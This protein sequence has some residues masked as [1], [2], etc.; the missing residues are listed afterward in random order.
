MLACH[1]TLICGLSLSLVHTYSAIHTHIQTLTHSHTHTHTHSHTHTF[2]HT[3]IHTKTTGDAFLSIDF[4]QLQIE[5]SQ[6]NQKIN[7]RTDELMALKVAAGTTVQH[8]NTNKVI[9]YIIK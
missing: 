2:A 8:L 4:D 9:I 7:E 3:Y 6:Y 5:N 1:H